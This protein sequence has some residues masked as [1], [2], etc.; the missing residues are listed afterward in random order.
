MA[1]EAASDRPKARPYFQSLAE[2]TRSLDSSR[3]VTMVSCKGTDDEVLDLFDVVSLNL[4]PGWY[5][6]PGQI[7]AAKEE[8]RRLLRAVHSKFRKP[9]FVAEF[10][11]DAIA[12]LHSLP[13]EQ[14]SEDYQTELILALMDV[15]REHDFVI[16]EHVWNFADF[17][18]GQQFARVGGNRKGVFTRDR[19]PKMAA[20]FLRRKWAEKRG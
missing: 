12:G 8:L 16:G 2:L 13:A 15:M 4:Y 6:F 11:A 10:G 14:W 9:V 20:H 7:D 18:T 5:E 1:N 17:R 3:P 19:Q